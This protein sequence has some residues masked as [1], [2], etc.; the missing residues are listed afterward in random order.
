MTRMKEQA[1]GKMLLLALFVVA[2][3]G[4]PGAQAQTTR[5]GTA[6]VT[7]ECLLSADAQ[8]IEALGMDELQA[9]KF[10]DLQKEV[11]AG[12]TDKPE[13]VDRSTAMDTHDRR[14]RALLS[15]DQ[16]DALL[17][18]CQARTPDTK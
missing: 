6:G 14:L 16:Y 1:H 4:L 13:G 2:V 8:A 15:G 9:G 12:M 17:S 5:T 10:R 7:E 3:V 11:Q 18:W